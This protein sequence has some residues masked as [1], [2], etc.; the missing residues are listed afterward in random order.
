MVSC[1]NWHWHTSLSSIHQIFITH[2]HD[3]TMPIGHLDG[4]CLDTGNTARRRCTGRADAVHAQ[5]I[6]AVFALTSP[7]VTSPGTQCSA[8]EHHAR[9]GIPGR[10]SFTE[11]ANVR[12]TAIE[13]CHYTSPGYAGLLT[14]SSL[15]HLRFQTADPVMSQRRYGTRGRSSL[16]SPRAR[17][18]RA[19]R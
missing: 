5:R 7:H 6:S 19:R 2:N 8:R 12:V 3:D 17:N 16:T 9:S 18:P 13:N 4:T 10:G 15:S 14:G 1:G 11:D